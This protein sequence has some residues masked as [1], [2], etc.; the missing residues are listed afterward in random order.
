M[1]GFPS[2]LWTR[3][4]RPQRRHCPS[5]VPVT[6]KGVTAPV[7]RTRARAERR[8]RFAHVISADYAS[9]EFRQNLGDGPEI[10]V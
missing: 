9:R 10:G 3:R 8:D 5:A 4:V 7:V 6:A 2:R 1:R